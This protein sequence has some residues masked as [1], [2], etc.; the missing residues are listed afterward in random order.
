MERTKLIFGIYIG[1]V[2]RVGDAT[3]YVTRSV[4]RGGISSIKL[5]IEAPKDTPIQYTRQKEYL[6]AGDNDGTDSKQ[7]NRA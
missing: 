6:T 3:I 7:I 5:C 2:I 1:Q 4:K